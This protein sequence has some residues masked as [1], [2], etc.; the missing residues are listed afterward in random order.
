MI[1]MLNDLHKTLC[2]AIGLLAY[3]ICKRRISRST[4]LHLKAILEQADGQI[5]QIELKMVEQ[6]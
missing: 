4:V 3:A 5:E 1:D 6:K 2:N